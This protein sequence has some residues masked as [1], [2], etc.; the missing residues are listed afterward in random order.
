MLKKIIVLL[1]FFIVSIAGIFFYIGN[2]INVYLQQPL[3]IKVPEIITIK[4]G[5]NLNNTLILL[6]E[7]NWISFNFISRLLPRFHPEFSDIKAGTFQLKPSMTLKKV[8]QHLVDGN[9]YQFSITFIEGTRFDDWRVTLFSSP[10]LKD[11]ISNLDEIEIANI[12]GI[13]RKKLE[14]LFLAET[15]YYTAGTSDIE[16]LKRAHS[17]LNQFINSK[18]LD[19]SPNLILNTPYEALILASIIEKETALYSE[20]RRIASVFF[21]RLNKGMR[22]Q[23]DPSV[24][25][26][27]A[28]KYNGNLSKE[29]LYILTPYN[30]YL[31]HGLPPT[32][33]AMTGKSS[34]EAAL[35]P[36][37][38]E[39]LYFVSNGEGEHIFS[40]NLLN[41]NR[42]VKQYLKN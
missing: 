41:H 29:D 1:V 9:E 30:T 10:Y 16:I 27:I 12:L 42:A 38:T 5:T 22:L 36:E 3:Q 14:G 31:I 32:P 15:Y 24:I 11:T 25:Y 23:T 2:Q 13:Q 6:T 26:G 4:S 37:Q 28:N 33:I 19:R 17:Q 40:K 7:N 18:W 39:Y 20:K 34:I 35:N 8:L 21:N